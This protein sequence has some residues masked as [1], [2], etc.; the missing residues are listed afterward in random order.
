MAQEARAYSA[1][2]MSQPYHAHPVPSRQVLPGQSRC[3]AVLV[4]RL[5]YRRLIA[6]GLIPGPVMQLRIMKERGSPGGYTGH[7]RVKLSQGVLIF[8]AGVNEQHVCLPGE[9]L[10]DPGVHVIPVNER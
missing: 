2:S 4:Q 1:D 8:M 7:E 5:R 6:R 3:A 10:P 9:L